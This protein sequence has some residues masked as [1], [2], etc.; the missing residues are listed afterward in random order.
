M[1]TFIFISAISITFILISCKDNS[2]PITPDPNLLYSADELTCDYHDSIPD[3]PIWIPLYSKKI[4]LQYNQKTFSKVKFVGNVENFSSKDTNTNP[5]LYIGLV[6]DTNYNPN[7]TLIRLN[8]YL[9]NFTIIDTIKYNSNES[10]NILFE[11]NIFP[12]YRG[13]YI[14]VTNIKIYKMD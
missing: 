5:Y 4:E 12:A 11:M 13:D 14:K 6:K 9:G 3:P 2:N 10:F 7:D 1:K 8:R